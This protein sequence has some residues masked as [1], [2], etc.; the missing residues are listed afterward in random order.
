MTKAL[1]LGFTIPLPDRISLRIHH[2]GGLFFVVQQG[3]RV[4]NHYLCAGSSPV[5]E[6]SPL[7]APC[8]ARSHS[9]ASYL[10]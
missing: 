4:A 3:E 7:Y 5:K 8:I 10:F 6:Q 2:N 1:D 9:A